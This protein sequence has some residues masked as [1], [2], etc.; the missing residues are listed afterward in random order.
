[1]RL[2]DYSAAL[3]ATDEWV[4]E[5]ASTNFP[6]RLYADYINQYPLLLE[7]RALL[8]ERLGRADEALKEMQ[9]ASRMPEYGHKNVSEALGLAAMYCR[10]NR[11][12]DALTAVSDLGP[13]ND[14]GYM[15]LEFVRLKAS[16]Q[17]HDETE[18]ASSLKFLAQYRTDSPG[19]YEL[20]L[21]RVGEMDAAAQ[22]LI[23]RLMSRS[24]RS[25]ALRNVQDFPL[26]SVIDREHSDPALWKTLIERDDVQA[27]ASK[28]GHVQHYQ[29][30]T[31]D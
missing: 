7:V 31:I 20:A 16:L 24:Q 23:A 18:A 19:T 12:K 6:Q 29:I 15:Q 30:D 21:V 1:M 13:L 27:A 9:R 2:R 22:S 25:G 5:I 11:P 8:L 14:D 4:L 28:V 26:P 3:A 10:L 17:L